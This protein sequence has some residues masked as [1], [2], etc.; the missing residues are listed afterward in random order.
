MDYMY[1][2]NK[3]KTYLSMNKSMQNSYLMGCMIS[4]NTGYD[5]P[6][7]NILLCKKDFKKIHSIG[8]IRLS[9]IQ[10]RLEKDNFIQRYIMDQRVGHSQT[11]HC[12]GCMISFPNMESVCQI[13]TQYIFQIISQGGKSTTCTKDMLK[14]LKEMVILLHMHILQEYERNNS[15][16]FVFLRS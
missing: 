16:I 12:H 5:Y 10:T 14:V 11:L 13:E 8:N 3:R 9:R 6:I 7:G 4:T 1:A 15:I 2:L